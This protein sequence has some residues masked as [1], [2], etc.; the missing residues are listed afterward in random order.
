MQ[1]SAG[2]SAAVGYTRLLGDE[3]VCVPAAAA[4]GE[5]EAALGHLVVVEPGHVA[6]ADTLVLHQRTLV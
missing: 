3:V 1:E 5:E 4:I 6:G 2:G